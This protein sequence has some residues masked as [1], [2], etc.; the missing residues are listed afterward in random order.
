LNK[1]GSCLDLYSLYREF[2]LTLMGQYVVS[3]ASYFAAVESSQT[4]EPAVVYGR[5]SKGQLQNIEMSSQL[6][7]ELQADKTVH[8]LSDLPNAAFRE[9]GLKLLRGTMQVVGPVYVGDTLVGI[10]FLGKRI[11][12]KRYTE[13]DLE[14][15]QTLCAASAVTFNNARLFENVKGSMEEVQR[16]SD[17]RDEMI[18]RISHEFRTPITAIRAAMACLPESGMPE[19]MADAL[20]H[21]VDRLQELID[22]LLSLN[23]MSTADLPSDWDVFDPATPISEFVAKNI[24]AATCKDLTFEIKQHTDIGRLSLRIPRDSFALV[25][26]KLLEN[27]IQF[28]NASSTIAIELDILSREPDE[29]ADGIVVA[30]WRDQ[31]R[32][33]INEYKSLIEGSG[34]GSDRPVDSD[35]AEDPTLASF[36]GSYLV[37]RIT[38]RG[39]GIPKDELRYIGEPFRQA[40]NSP[41]QRVKGKALGLAVVHKILTDCRGHL[42]CMS[43]EGVATTFSVFLPLA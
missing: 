27:A 14:L 23:T 8:K 20:V 29:H 34:A 22:S 41:D 9:P 36:G 28:S 5:I 2:T 18:S 4:L 24:E 32:K 21:S 12:G 38:D 17:L 33:T 15:L 16:L 35:T 25:V 11:S 1:Y 40:S 30:D 37:L 6:I 31:T 13:F 26:E 42:C 7:T 43:E 19:P 3:D 39:I 10:V